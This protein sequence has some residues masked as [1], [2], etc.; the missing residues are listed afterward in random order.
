M[1]LL[2]LLIFRR[3]PLK[4][5]F[6]WGKLAAFLMNTFRCF[7]SMCAFFILFALYVFTF[8]WATRRGWLNLHITQDCVIYS[9]VNFTA[10]LPNLLVRSIKSLN[11]RWFFFIFVDGLVWFCKISEWKIVMHETIVLR[12][13]RIFNINFCSLIHFALLVKFVLVHLQISVL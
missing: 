2:W 3:P 10:F 5:I 13:I 9:E 1:R 7:Q 12:S 11:W 4:S 8:S 6:S